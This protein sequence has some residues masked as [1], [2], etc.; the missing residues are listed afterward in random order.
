VTNLG[1]PVDSR[2]T[3]LSLRPDRWWR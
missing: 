1:G 2:L 3:A